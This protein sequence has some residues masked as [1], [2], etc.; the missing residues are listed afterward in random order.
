MHSPYQR[1]CVSVLVFC[2]FVLACVFSLCAEEISTGRTEILKWPDGKR[3]AI[4][5]TY[6]DGT[7]NQFK[8]ALPL[9]QELGLPATFFIITGEVQGSKYKPA[10]FGRPFDAILGESESA[11]TDNK[12]FL[13]RSSAIKFSGYKGAE[14]IHT[15]VGE[16]FEDEKIQE[17]YRLIDDTF[18][19]IRNGEIK[20]EPVDHPIGP[21]SWSDFRKIAERGYEFA[22]H[23]ISHPY[24]SVLDDRN[25]SYELEKSRQEILEQLGEKHTFSVEC[26]YGT[27]NERAVQAA[28]KIYPLT[29]N[30][31]PDE[32]VQDLNRWDDQDPGASKKAYVRWQRG[33]LSDTPLGLMKQ[34]VDTSIRSDNVWLTLVFH[35]VDGIGWEPLPRSKLETYFKYIKSHDKEVWVA[36]FQDAGKYIREKMSGKIAAE[37][38]E[39]SIRITLTHSLDPKLYDLPLSLKTYV[40]SGWKRVTAEQD[41]S[42]R[43]FPVSR[44]SNGSYVVYS[45]VPNVGEVTL[46][47]Q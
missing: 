24:L 19:K 34:W 5:I 17:A 38:L 39:Q 20:L 47:S 22:S 21:M 18:T 12:N 41:G 35:G 25:L 31:I 37:S 7:E 33:A 46:S 42:T 6:D 30:L 11:P 4:S 15:H 26:P 45:A 27:E 3:A 14:D 9:M 16:L 44:D 13:E 28:L 10:Y 23:T 2:G 29:R 43:V 8:V 1:F 32:D 40:P 36:T